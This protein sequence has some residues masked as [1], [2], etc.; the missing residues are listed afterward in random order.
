MDPLA[1]TFGTTL[2]TA[3]TTPAWPR[4]RT[5]AV[6]LWREARPDQAGAVER[7]LTDARALALAAKDE[8][9]TDTER[10]LAGSW[11]LRLQRLL[12]DSPALAPEI[13][14][15]LDEVLTPALAPAA[16]PGRTATMTA[17]ARDH[18]RIYQ[19]AGNQ[20]ITEHGAGGQE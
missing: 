5:A 8:G 4:A 9:D 1:K 17:T 19:A 20:Y 10:A 14:R 13:Q 11:Q 2:V 18:G 3:M 16:R 7:D 6:Q 15:V 12:R